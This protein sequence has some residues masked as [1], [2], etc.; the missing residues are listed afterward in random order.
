MKFVLIR[1]S[2]LVKSVFGFKW[3]LSTSSASKFG[4][5]MQESCWFLTLS[6][7]FFI[8]ERSD[9]ELQKRRNKIWLKLFLSTRPP[10]R[11]SISGQNLR[12]EMQLKN[13]AHRSFAI[14]SYPQTT[15][16][17]FLK[18]IASNFLLSNQQS[19]IVLL[20]MISIWL[21][22]LSS[23]VYRLSAEMAI[24]IA[25][26]FLARSFLVEMNIKLTKNFF[27]INRQLQSCREIYEKLYN[28]RSKGTMMP[29]K[30]TSSLELSEVHFRSKSL[31][32][33]IALN[34]FKFQLSNFLSWKFVLPTL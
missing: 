3:K 32:R 16:I 27:A 20:I 21:T 8:K 33:C 5:Q 29:G 6:L 15:S 23:C 10:N 24:Q 17:L 26:N 13:T 31:P 4:D 12:I 34:W 25:K 19:K 28:W 22:K 18:F 30:F 11:I 14:W 7:H 2:I 9:S 1:T